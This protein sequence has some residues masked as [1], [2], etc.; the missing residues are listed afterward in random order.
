MY[1]GPLYD[2]RRGP[3][4]TESMERLP[5][6]HPLKSTVD[7]DVARIEAVTSLNAFG[8]NKGFGIA[9]KDPD[10]EEKGQDMTVLYE[11]PSYCN[12]SCIPSANKTIAGDVMVLRAARAIKAGEEVT[13]SYVSADSSLT[14][15]TEMLKK[16]WKFSCDCVLC[17]A[18]RSD[19]M[20]I[21]ATRAEL[22]KK[23]ESLGHL[24]EAGQA[25]IPKEA[26]RR[27]PSVK[28]ILDSAIELQEG[29]DEWY[30]CAFKPE[31]FVIAC[32]LSR[33]AMMRC[34]RV[35]ASQTL[36]I[37]D[38]EM[39]VLELAGFVIQDRRLSELGQGN[40]LDLER[41]YCPSV[42][43]GRCVEGCLIIAKAAD[44]LNCKNAIRAW[45]NAAKWSKLFPLN[46]I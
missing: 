10:V 17:K 31:L 19:G 23:A 20:S 32:Q 6:E 25:D 45:V 13:L 2:T 11:I 5:L 34:S 43:Y 38:A 21:C 4:P 1:A 12:H 28:S 15:R 36:A 35:E 8:T 46:P 39:Q 37:I 3:L 44:V 26:G 16:K 40:P 29:S 42:F 27:Y 7:I 41:S 24:Y 14:V 9:R 18:E 30:R 22:C 33:M